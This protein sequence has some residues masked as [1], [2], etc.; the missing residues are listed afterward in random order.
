MRCHILGCLSN[1]KLL[2]IVLGLR[3][4]RSR[5][6]LIRFSSEGSLPGLQ[7]A[8]FSLCPLRQRERE[9]WREMK[10]VRRGEQREGRETEFILSSSS[11]KTLNPS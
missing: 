6:W 5:C 10:R 9:R 2:L 4:L 1:R 7:I 3:N 8:A 11:Y